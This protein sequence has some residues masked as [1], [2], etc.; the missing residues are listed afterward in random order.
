VAR[1]FLLSADA[2]RCC[3]PGRDLNRHGWRAPI[4]RPASRAHRSDELAGGEPLGG[5]GPRLHAPSPGRVVLALGPMIEH[6]CVGRQPLARLPRWPTSPLT[7]HLSGDDWLRA[8]PSAAALKSARHS[9]AR[10]IRPADRRSGARHSTTAVL[11]RG[12]SPE[13]SWPDWKRIQRRP[14]DARCPL[15]ADAAPAAH[16]HLGQSIN[17]APLMELTSRSDSSRSGRSGPKSC[18]RPRSARRD[19]ASGPPPSPPR[20][21][22]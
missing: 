17:V 10:P 18:A 7:A 20:R 11:A 6:E 12:Q 3:W 8:R 2:A 4:C 9:I 22:L 14:R 15:A 13:S 19:L 21:Q 5:G 1:S 16:N